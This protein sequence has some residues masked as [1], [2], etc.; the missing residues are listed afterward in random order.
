MGLSFLNGAFLGGL[1]LVGLPILIHLLQRRR[2][3][4]VKWGAMEFLRLSQRNRSRR[5]MIE[6]LLLLLI[7]C[8]VIALVVLA[9][10]RPIVR[11]GALP[12]ASARGQ[13]HAIVILDNS[14]S[15]GYRP[16]GTSGETVFSR[17]LAR[18]LDVC[19]R[20]LRQGDAISIVLASDPPRLL[21]G[22]PSLDLHAAAALLRRVTLSDAGT[23]YGKAARLA[24]EIAGQST[25]ANREV[26]LISDNQ[27]GGWQGP[28]RDPGAWEALGKLA[29]L[30]MLPVREGPA[31]NLAV[32]WVQAA[33]GLAT[34]RAPARIQARI[35]NRGTQPARGLMIRLEIDGKPEA[36]AQRVDV[37]PGQGALV[38]FNQI[39]DQPGVHECVIRL[40]AD[41]LPA[42][43]AGYLALRVRNSVRVLVVNGNPNA[44][45][46]QK[47]GA[48]FLQ[49]ALSPPAG[50]GAE[51]TPLEPKLAR[52]AG[53]AGSNVRDFDVVLLS[54]VAALSEGDRRLLGEFVQNGGGVVLFLGSRVNGSLYNRDLLD[55]APKL[56]PARLGAVASGKAALDPTALDHP[57]LQRFRG[58]Q[59]VDVGTAEFSRYFKLV[60]ATGDKS[61]H[62]MARFNNG[63]PALVERQFG[64]GKVVV[65]AST[66][67]MEWNTLP[68]KPVFLPLIH[69]LVA[70]LASGA[71]GTRNG[72]V[73]E[74]LVKPLPLGEASRRVT[75]TEPSGAQASLKPSVEER[76][77]VVTVEH[78]QAAGFYRL[79]VEQ[80]SRDVFAVNR[81]TAESDLK[82]LDQAALKRL[83]PVRAWTWIGLNEDLLSALSRSRQGIELWRHLLLA[84]LG[85]M[86]LETMLAQL[87]GRRS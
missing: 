60:P 83:L 31:P 33:R 69:Q 47:D 29:R 34:A 12:I 38:T 39:F 85:L 24:L 50:P 58:A 36:T 32:E 79:A 7:R 18:A 44:A 80:G 30:V 35:V 19:Q 81:D 17:A 61:V 9:V 62:V 2:F 10:C 52:G 48:F 21:I 64:L 77:A 28:G 63:D 37:E 40:P 87:F 14:Y 86:V 4:V 42:D 56:L 67:T 20:G 6:Q 43:D 41:R 75:V 46:P 22:K 3:R 5:L 57:A 1:S 71:D 13:V 65:V 84:A 53:F 82:S 78:P 70:Y 72:R 66:A 25:F 23:N 54:D 26:Y 45:S 74:P 76:G 49:L 15:M 51:P 11:V 8:L 73:G 59:D 27:A 68:A 16:S 55:G